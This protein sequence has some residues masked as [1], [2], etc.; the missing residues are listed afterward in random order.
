MM[1]RGQ[2][3]FVGIVL[4]LLLVV[5][6]GAAGLRLSQQEL[7]EGVTLFRAG[8]NIV[9]LM[10]GVVDRD[11]RF[12]TGL[13]KDDFAVYEDGA[14]QEVEFF[15]ATGVPLDL[16]ILIDASSSMQDK[17]SLVQDAAA[18]FARTL[19]PDDRGAVVEFNNSARFLSGFTSSI[20][21]LEAAIRG[22]SAKGKTALYNAIY[23]TL[24]EFEKLPLDGDQVRRQAIAVLSDG[25]DT[26]SLVGVDQ[27]IEQAR[28]A[29]VRIYTV[30]LISPSKAEVGRAYG[31]H[32]YTS[33]ADQ[34]MATLARDSGARSFFPSK[35]GDLSDVYSLIAE[36]LSKL[37]VLGFASS[38]SA[39]DDTF[40]TLRVQILTRPN[41]FAKT[42]AGYFASRPSESPTR[43][44]PSR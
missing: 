4:V 12:V 18:G 13:T 15:S 39:G 11:D 26:A 1:T 42:R 33:E 10:I 34:A 21:D 6:G 44:R 9:S 36:E 43:P 7:P 32:Q 14:R 27:V 25:D 19:Q 23:V 41:A 3:T 2:T 35:L 17:L 29:S 8:V 31:G 20:D 37:Y 40:R 16:A 28:R 5:P 22:T 30:S 38:A 24:N